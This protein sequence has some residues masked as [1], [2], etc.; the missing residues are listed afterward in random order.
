MDDFDPQLAALDQ[1][2]DE[3]Q[4]DDGLRMAVQMCRHSG[5]TAGAA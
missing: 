1:L 5:P 4:T 2:F 3:G